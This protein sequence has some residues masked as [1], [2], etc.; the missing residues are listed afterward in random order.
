MSA[1]VIYFRPYYWLSLLLFLCP[2]KHAVGAEDFLVQTSLQ[3]SAVAINAHATIQAPLALI[4]STLTDYNSLSEFIPGM[5]KSHL[6][7]RRGGTAVVEQH[8]SAG[9]LFFSSPINVVVDSIEEPPYIIGVKK[10]T[11]NVKQLEG[12]YQIDKL[13]NADDRYILRWIGIIEPELYMPAFM[14]EMLIRTNV[15]DQFSGMVK[16][17]ER[18]QGLKNLSQ[19]IAV[20]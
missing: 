20:E 13:D 16:E 18:R 10:V 17:I 5:D 15:S 3:G 6:I 19:S 9:F 1:I 12:H 11:G 2:I 8:G 7:E 4:W 14:S